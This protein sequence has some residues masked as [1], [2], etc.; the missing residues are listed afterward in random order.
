M[1]DSLYQTNNDRC[2]NFRQIMQIS[3]ERC[4]QI[5]NINN[6][7]IAII[8]AVFLGLF[9]ITINFFASPHSENSYLIIVA[10]HVVIVTLLIWRYYSHVL[11]NE[12]VSCYKKILYCEEKLDIPFEISLASWLEKNIEFELPP[13]YKNSVELSRKKKYIE[14]NDTKKNLI[15]QK[16]IEL[17]KSGYRFHNIWDNVAG[18]SISILLVY[19]LLYLDFNFNRYQYLFL[20]A[21]VII[22]IADGIALWGLTIDSKNNIAIQRDPKNAEF[23]EIIEGVN[24]SK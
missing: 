11:D 21:A 14:Q 4:N 22:P 8:A 24:N 16:L 12:L 10:I 15:I 9:T 19:Q 23:E 20:T 5:K 3:Y 7:L 6:Q 18:C 1:S 17:N 2:Q 13:P